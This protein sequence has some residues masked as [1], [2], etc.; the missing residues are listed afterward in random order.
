MRLEAIIPAPA[1]RFVIVHYHIF[2]NGGST[3][4]SILEREFG[5]E[6]ATLHGPGASSTLDAGDLEYF[7]E[8]HPQVRA[9]SSH[10]LRYPKPAIRHTVIFDCCFLRH[11]LD[12]IDSMFWYLRE[13]DAGDELCERARRQSPREFL[14]G[15]LK[16]SPHVISDIQVNQLA[17][18]GVF[19]RP[20]NEG[21]LERASETFQQA[22]I[23]G[24]V[25]MFDLSLTTAEYFLRPAF[26]ALRME[27]TPRNIRRVGGDHGGQSRAERLTR[28]WGADV[29]QDLIR[30][31]QLDLELFDR[32]E[33]EIRRRAA[34]VPGCE[35]RRADFKARCSRL[36][37][38][39]SGTVVEIP[40][41]AGR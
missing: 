21:D 5:R 14:R 38:G 18:S 9:V 17:C 26:P 15:L 35:Q 34:L 33:R 30:L 29:Y 2:K 19:A 4:E 6:F 7:L 16:E 10:H 8:E 40:V 32:A 36:R 39:Q 28:S 12:R 13:A 1:P 11:P 3:L 24:V 22:A 23:P 31:N 37:A 25:E 41:S 20:A 27:Y